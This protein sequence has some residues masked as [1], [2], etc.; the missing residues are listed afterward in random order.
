MISQNKG[1]RGEVDSTFIKI[2]KLSFSGSYDKEVR[3]LTS[4]CKRSINVLLTWEYNKISDLGTDEV[5][6]IVE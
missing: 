6:E 4:Y 5:V 3:N 2:F 1:Y